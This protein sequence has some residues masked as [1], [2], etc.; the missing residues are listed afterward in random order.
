MHYKKSRFCLSKPST[1]HRVH[2]SVVYH[3]LVCVATVAFFNRRP[4]GQFPVR[5]RLPV[6]P[7]GQ[8]L[9]KVSNTSVF[10]SSSTWVAELF[11][12]GTVSFPQAS[13]VQSHTG[14]EPEQ[15]ADGSWPSDVF[16][17]AFRFFFFPVLANSSCRTV[18]VSYILFS[19]SLSFSSGCFL[20]VYRERIMAL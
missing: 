9:E 16:C 8:Q 12:A 7:T 3:R 10:F 1:I 14:A 6:P 13:T 5:R 15:R 19:S 2:A 18:T 11:P 20:C 17:Q 4:H